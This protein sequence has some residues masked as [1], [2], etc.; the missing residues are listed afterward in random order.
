MQARVR[1]EF[2][3]DFIA[4][5]GHELEH[6]LGHSRAPECLDN[7]PGRIDGQLGRLE[8]HRVP[9][10]QRG[11]HASG[12]NGKGEVPRGHH[13]NGTQ[14]GHF[15]PVIHAVPVQAFRIITAEV[16]GFT[17]FHIR[18]RGRLARIPDH[19]G[20][21]L[22]ADGGEF[23]RGVVQD[24]RTLTDASGRPGSPRL[25]GRV[26]GMFNPVEVRV[27]ELVGDLVV[28]GTGSRPTPHR[29][30]VICSP[31]MTRGISS[32]DFSFSA[33]IRPLIHSE[34]CRRDQSVSRS[35]AK[36]SR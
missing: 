4:R 10:H 31:L 7:L 8:D 16:N 32:P 21:S 14:R 11:G 18:F 3:G 26:Q 13:A 19:G 5:H 9:G 24:F 27:G 29:L 6:L 25:V 20:N 12:G 1:Q 30:V 15:H 17:H 28:P 22:P 23:P 2:V 36:A 35:L 33:A 34:F